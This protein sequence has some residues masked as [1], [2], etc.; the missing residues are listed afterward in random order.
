MS[1]SEGATAVE[2]GEDFVADPYQ[3]LAA[4]VLKQAL[5]DALANDAVL[6]WLAGPRALC[7]FAL[8]T[9]R[10]AAPED[11]QQTALQALLRRRRNMRRRLAYTA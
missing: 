1:G 6:R 5:D 7:W 8:V 4:A 2:P 11:I 3:L 10:D 9:P